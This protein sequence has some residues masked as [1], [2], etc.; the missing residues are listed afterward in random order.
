MGKP[1][2]ITAQVEIPRRLARGLLAPPSSLVRLPNR[3]DIN[4][5]GVQRGKANG[6]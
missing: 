1:Q 4:F 6:I 3:A 5:Q 2:G